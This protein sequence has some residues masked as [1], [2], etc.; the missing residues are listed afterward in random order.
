MGELEGAL[1]Y[2]LFDGN[3]QD[4]FCSELFQFADDFPEA[5]LL[6]DRVNATPP[7][8]CKRHHG[9]TLRAWKDSHYVLDA[10]CRDV[11]QDV[12]LVFGSLNGFDAEQEFVEHSLLLVVKVLVGDEDGLALHH[13]FHFD[14]V[15][16]D[17]C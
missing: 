5:L 12:L 7:L 2:H 8:C 13:S 17:E 10:V 1:W 4:A 11:H 15:V 16:A 3:Y 6:D 9:G 14:E